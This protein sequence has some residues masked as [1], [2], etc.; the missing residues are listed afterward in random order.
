MLALSAKVYEARVEAARRF[1]QDYAASIK[2]F[3]FSKG[4]L[5][6][7]R[8]TAIEKALNRKMRARYLG[9]YVVLAR[10]RGGAYI[11]S[12]LDGTVLDRPIGAFRV[13]PYFA[14]KTIELDESILDVDEPRIRAMQESFA[15]GDEDSTAGHEQIEDS[16]SEMPS[17]EDP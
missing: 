3:N 9:P 1:E 5:V 16:D 10:N 15:K 7:V 13:V 12:E 17:V 11:V 6:L 4:A 2:D 14:R 8:N